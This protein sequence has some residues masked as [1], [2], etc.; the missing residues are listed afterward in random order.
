MS[1]HNYSCPHCGGQIVALPSKT[2]R[3]TKSTFQSTAEYHRYS[4]PGF[5]YATLSL[6]RFLVGR[7]PDVTPLNTSVVSP[8]A[9][10][11]IQVEM[12]SADRRH[13]I[14]D[15]LP[16]GFEMVDLELAAD[17]VIG[18]G[19]NWSRPV[20]TRRGMSQSRYHKLTDVFLAR[21]WC[22]PDPRAKRT[23]VSPTG[24]AILR[25]IHRGVNKQQTTN[26]N[27]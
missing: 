27:E 4:R 14:L 16:D 3:A 11:R 21:G 10:T 7:R 18:R 6:L 20:F 22:V 23:H 8:V 1:N 2:R 13:W 26:N 9:K 12:V 17:C 24:A 25:H 19:E 5:F 15:E